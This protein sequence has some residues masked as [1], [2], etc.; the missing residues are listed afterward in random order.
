MGTHP[1]SLTS[2]LLC[3]WGIWV[4]AVLGILYQQMFHEMFKMVDTIFY[5]VIGVA[6]SLAVVEMVSSS[7]A[8]FKC[9]HVKILQISDNGRCWMLL[10][11]IGFWMLLL[12]IEFWMLLLGIGL[13]MLLLG[14]VFW[15]LLLGIVFWM[16]LLGIGCWMLLLGIRCWMLLLGIGCW[17]LLLVIGCWLLWM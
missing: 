17:M 5:V 16:L 7:E 1:H 12:G 11:G 6:P 3:R 15:M 4:L 14:I 13:W 2:F 8:H 9:I 10:L